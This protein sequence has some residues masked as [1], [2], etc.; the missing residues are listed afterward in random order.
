MNAPHEEAAEFAKQSKRENRVYVGNLSYDVRYR[1]LMEFMRGGGW[2]ILG[3]SSS[4]EN[5]V[6]EKEEVFASSN[7]VAATIALV[8]AFAWFASGMVWTMVRLREVW[9]WHWVRMRIG[10]GITLTVEAGVQV[11]EVMETEVGGCGGGSGFEEKS[12]RTWLQSGL[13]EGLGQLER[14]AGGHRGDWLEAL[15]RYYRAD[16]FL[17]ISGLAYGVA[18]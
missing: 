15:Q 12:G 14:R 10:A 6:S 11:A 17:G 9:L 2:G 4:L 1:D 16:V 7:A 5:S 18:S 13:S 8:F 3:S